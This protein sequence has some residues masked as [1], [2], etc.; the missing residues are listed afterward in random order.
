M[1]RNVVFL[2]LLL[3]ITG[4]ASVFDTLIPKDPNSSARS[5][6]VV[7]VYFARTAEAAFS[8]QAVTAIA[9]FVIDQFAAGIEAES[10]LYSAS[11]SGRYSDYF[12]VNNLADQYQP[13]LV[14]NIAIIERYYGDVAK[15]NGCQYSAADEQTRNQLD[16]ERVMI[17]TA[18]FELGESKDVFR[19]TPIGFNIKKSKAKV[20][21]FNGKVDVNVQLVLG[22]FVKNEKGAIS[23]TDIAK[24]DFPL[25]KVELPTTFDDKRLENLRTG[26]I[27]IPVQG[28]KGAAKLLPVNLVITVMESDDFG[29]VIAKGA[30]TL[31]ENKAKIV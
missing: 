26:W 19:I 30:K 29:D 9:G 13:Q 8:D 4:C 25:G 5:P 11:Y 24:V 16:E 17:F 12:L 21:W 31:G 3:G 20:S 15:K 14:Y 1:Q 22:G 7:C 28:G 18:K 23:Q 2:A 10:K 27:P 6:E